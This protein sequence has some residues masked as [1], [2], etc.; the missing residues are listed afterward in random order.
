MKNADD[1]MY[2]L[3]VKVVSNLV[4]YVMAEIRDTAELNHFEESWVVSEFRA[5]L[6]QRFKEEGWT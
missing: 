2:D 6:N 4:D 1:V 3:A 5:Q